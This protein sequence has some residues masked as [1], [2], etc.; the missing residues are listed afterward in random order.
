MGK[1]RQN[2]QYREKS[3]SEE[4]VVLSAAEVPYKLHN[5]GCLNKCLKCSKHKI[6]FT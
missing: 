4:G 3:R 6:D 1:L 2:V 5:V